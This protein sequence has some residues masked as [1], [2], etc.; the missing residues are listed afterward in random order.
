MAIETGM[1]ANFKPADIAGAL[2]QGQR[3]KESR[4]RLSAFQEDS[5][6][7]KALIDREEQQKK[8]MAIGGGLEELRNVPE[9]QRPDV[10]KNKIVPGLIKFG[11]IGP[12]DVPPEY[13]KGFV[14][15]AYYQLSNNKD[16]LEL[17]KA[18]AENQ[19]TIA[20]TDPNS[21]VSKRSR[22]A[23][24]AVLGRVGLGGSISDQMSADEVNQFAKDGLAGKAI[25]GV[26][27]TEGRRITA[28]RFQNYRNERATTA[29]IRTA[30]AIAR[31]P[32]ITK[33]TNKLNAARGVQSL[34]EAIQSGEVKGSKNIAKQL[35]NMIATIEMGGPGAVADRQAM[36]VDT[37]Y[38]TAKGLLGYVTSSPTDV[39][40]SEYLTQLE[41]E[42]NA[43]GD[44]AAQ[45]YKNLLDSQI[46]LS[47]Q[48]D[49]NDQRDP[50]N[51]SKMVKAKKDKLLQSSGYDPDT[52]ERI[53][54]KEKMDKKSGA[55]QPSGKI[56][57]EAP[58]G[59][60]FYVSESQKGDAISA[61]G[62]V[63][64]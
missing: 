14:D 19:R 24:R 3:E 39:I 8:L 34:V 54:N 48:S 11:A 9:E 60:R 18:R 59:K 31:D 40:P 35:T 1:Y 46:S 7:K 16:Y 57:M 37:L 45:N 2:E 44:R 22:E 4:A 20:A 29:D 26:L 62:K 28:D 52:G 56:L 27:G 6:R 47:D 61:G 12:N 53:N 5:A 49:F 43:L 36:G 58:N 50:G 42:A 25:S 23:N 13:D 51:I 63:I 55:S 30:N 15:S 33:E 21:D 38:T 41:L 17:Q 10:Y 32:N 64:K